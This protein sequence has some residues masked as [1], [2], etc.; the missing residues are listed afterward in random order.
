MTR[1]T[2]SSDFMK[3]HSTLSLRLLSILLGGALVSAM[4]LMEALWVVAFMHGAAVVAMLMLRPDRF[5]T[6]WNQVL[7]LLIIPIVF[8][9]G[10][11]DATP[12]K[13][14][15]LFVWALGYLGILFGIYQNVRNLSVAIKKS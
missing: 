8:I 3:L 4:L 1:A 12:L 6:K 2:I 15:L 9:Y 13:R 5:R 10:F 7:L 14:G 11:P